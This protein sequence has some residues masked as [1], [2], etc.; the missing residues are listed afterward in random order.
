MKCLNCGK[1]TDA[2]LCPDC[3]TE[4][5]LDKVF[6]DLMFYNPDKCENPVI[7]E[8]VS[9]L[10]ERYAEL[11]AIPELLKLFPESISDFYFCRYYK[12]SRNPSFEAKACEYLNTHNL[13]ERKSQ[14]VLYDLLT[15]Y[16][17]GN[18]LSPMSWC[19][20]AADAD[21]F[22][23]E[24]Y[25]QAA[26]YFGMIGEYDLSDQIVEKGLRLCSDE[27]YQGFLF[28]ER[29]CAVENLEKQKKDTERYRTKKPYWPKTEERR[30]AI[31]LIYDEKGISYGRIAGKPSK[32]AEADFEPLHEIYDCDP[33]NYCAF[34][35][36][37]AFSLG[38]VKPIYEIAA[39]RVRN[40]AAVDSFRQLIRPWDNHRSKEDAAKK[41]GVPL[42]EI[43]TAPDVDQV[44]PKFL[45]FV[46]ADP[47]VSTDALGS[48]A[49]LLSRAARYS[50]LREIKNEM[51]DLL[52]YAADMS[53]ELAAADRQMLLQRFGVPEGANALE[54]AAANTAL[55]K[56]LTAL[57][58]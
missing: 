2:F 35:C 22:C 16:I 4:D 39:I 14:W 51:F 45:E 56:A 20:S 50:G 47:L 25:E 57:G 5:I 54:C 52:D 27:R 9:G 53:D 43:D 7:S 32:I 48:Q 21:D 31:A 28:Q 15:F 40:G 55:F 41:A 38:P 6:L 42:S 12:R 17:P 29:E 10:S 18:Y 46:G 37:A 58:E 49:K 1:E 36:S 3:I 44:I 23:I 34:W 8:Y 19:R 30:R 11:D 24:I 33:E 26:K 13:S